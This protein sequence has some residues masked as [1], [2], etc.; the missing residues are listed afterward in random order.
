MPM[1][2]NIHTNIHTLKHTHVQVNPEA[3]VKVPMLYVRCELHG[4]SLKAFVDT[5][6]QMTVMASSCVM[7]AQARS[8]SPASH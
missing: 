7:R 4:V 3:F 8:A 1:L 2:Y 6:A 5:G